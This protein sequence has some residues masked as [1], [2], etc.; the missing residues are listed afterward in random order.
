L[1][2]LL[3]DNNSFLV[4]ITNDRKL[5]IPMVIDTFSKYLDNLI[6]SKIMN[7]CVTLDNSIKSLKEGFN[8]NDT[9][10]FDIEKIMNSKTLKELNN[11]SNKLINDHS[12][13]FNKVR[14]TIIN[15]NDNDIQEFKNYI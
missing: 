6:Y 4:D 14:K 1:K 8:L 2:P 9:Y 15:K 3:G 5:G 13:I 7:L 10:S 11:I 12:L